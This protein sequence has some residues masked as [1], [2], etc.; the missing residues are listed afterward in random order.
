MRPGVGTASWSGGHWH[1]EQEGL[2]AAVGTSTS[3]LKR[4][5][6]SPAFVPAASQSVRGPKFVVVKARRAVGM[7]RAVTWGDESVGEG[8]PSA[9]CGFP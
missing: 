6:A 7:H 5:L 8:G 3:W 4:R 1:V 2:V 9:V